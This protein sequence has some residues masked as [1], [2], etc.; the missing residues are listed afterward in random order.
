MTSSQS[1]AGYSPD[2][3]WSAREA[4]AF[5]KAIAPYNV[6]AIVHGHTHACVFYK[7][8][9]TT[10]TGKVYPVFNAPALQKGGPK[11]PAS[12]PSQFL[13]FEID[14]AAKSLRVFQRVGSSWG[15]VMYEGSFAGGSK[16]V[17]GRTEP[18]VVGD[19]VVIA[20]EPPVLHRSVVV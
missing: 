5:A 14:P 8:D 16:L 19:T 3:W 13:A 15:S 7:W 1:K 6:V 18:A 17:A 9:L 12:T 20:E 4:T 11:D 10:V 2:F